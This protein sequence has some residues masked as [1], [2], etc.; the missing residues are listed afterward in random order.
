MMPRAVSYKRSATSRYLT[1]MP[2]SGATGM[3]CGALMCR[4]QIRRFESGVPAIQL[5][6]TG[7]A[8]TGSSATWRRISLATKIKAERVAQFA[9]SLSNS[10]AH[11]DREAE[12]WAVRVWRR[13]MGASELF[14]APQRRHSVPAPGLQEQ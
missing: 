2:G 7:T 1:R 12:N 8:L 11:G 10:G 6:F 14:R 5:Q 9:S 3:L 13:H 4:R